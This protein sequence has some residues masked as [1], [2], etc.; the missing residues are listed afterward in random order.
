MNFYIGRFCSLR[1]A[2]WSFPRY[3]ES[4]LYNNF[5]FPCVYYI[6]SQSEPLI[7]YTNNMCKEYQ[8]WSELLSNVLFAVNCQLMSDCCYRTVLRSLSLALYH[9]ANQQ[10][11]VGVEVGCSGSC[12]SVS[13][14]MAAF[15]KKNPLVSRSTLC[16][17]LL[18]LLLYQFK[19]RIQM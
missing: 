12:A 6:Y 2:N 3:F 4:H 1:T 18:V 11:W 10:L 15:K 13:I 5:L 19:M 14:T 17:V 16:A 9:F 7:F 8:L